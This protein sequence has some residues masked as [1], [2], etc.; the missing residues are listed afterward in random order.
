MPKRP[1]GKFDISE[2]VDPSANEDWIKTPENRESEAEIHDS[3]A[4]GES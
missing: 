1:I 3:L 2:T 4:G